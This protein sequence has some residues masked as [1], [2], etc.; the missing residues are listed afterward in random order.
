[1]KIQDMP[2]S[3]RPR[4]RMIAHGVRALSNS[5]LLAIIIRTGT[6]QMNAVEVAVHL[7]RFTEGKLGELCQLGMEGLQRIPGIGR[8]KAMQIM[9]GIE[10]SRRMA[11][12]TARNENGTIRTPEDAFMNCAPLYDSDRIEQCWCVFLKA[13]RKILGR[14]MV[15]SG[16]ECMTAINS[17][18]IVRKALDLGARAIILSH[19][20][21]SGETEPSQQDIAATEKL[22]EALQPFEITLMDHIILGTNSWFSFM[23]QETFTKSG[24]NCN[25]V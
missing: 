4:E 12:E 17:K 10:L 5:E 15:S 18:A 23:K 2:Q 11:E 7:L 25:K 21:P 6:P 19:N 8:S 3:E 16:G 9:A 22:V 13:N 24:K 20:H 14:M 1:M